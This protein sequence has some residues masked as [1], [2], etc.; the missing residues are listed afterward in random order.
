MPGM[1]DTILNLGLNDEIVEGLAKKTD[2]P[3]FAY[4]SGRNSFEGF[5]TR[6]L[7]A[8][9]EKTLACNPAVEH[10]LALALLDRLFEPNYLLSQLQVIDIRA[11]EAQQPL[12]FDDAFYPVPRPRRALSI[13]CRPS[14]ATVSLPWS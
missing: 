4:D 13:P 9:I 5:A 11:G 8:V 3:R 12:H 1:M 2:N 10:P 6:R 14:A 7:Y